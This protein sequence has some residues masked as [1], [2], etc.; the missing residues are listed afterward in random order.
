VAERI[1][2]SLRDIGR[3]VR[4]DATAAKLMLGG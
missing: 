3:A 2:H 1:L 4:S